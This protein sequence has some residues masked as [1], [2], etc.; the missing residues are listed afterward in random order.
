MASPHLKLLSKIPLED[1]GAHVRRAPGKG[2]NPGTWG[3]LTL[4]GK[5]PQ[6]TGTSVTLCVNYTLM[7][8]PTEQVKE[9]PGN[10]SNVLG[11]AGLKEVQSGASVVNRK[12]SPGKQGEAPESLEGQRPWVNLG[13][14]GRGRARG[15]G[16]GGSG[17]PGGEAP[18]GAGCPTTWRPPAEENS[19]SG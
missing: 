16:L 6:E 11:G 17:R 8:Q 4:A 18:G 3:R 1:G 9:P 13:K 10:V 2:A 12:V 19:P 7:Q 15:R 5:K 14:R